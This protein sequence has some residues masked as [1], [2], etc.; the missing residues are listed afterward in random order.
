MH[1]FPMVQSRTQRMVCIISP[2]VTSEEYDEWLAK[3]YA[4]EAYQA[5]H[6]DL[7]R[8]KQLLVDGTTEEFRLIAM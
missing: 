5:L 4:D 1:P 3:L 6:L 2:E 7:R 8:D